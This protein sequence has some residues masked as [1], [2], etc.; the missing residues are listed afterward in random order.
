MGGFFRSF[1]RWYFKFLRLLF[2]SSDS[3]HKLALGGAIGCFWGLTP[4]V[5]L[6]ITILTVTY[7]LLYF[8]NKISANRLKVLE[9]NL[10]IAIAL[11]WVSNPLNAPVLYF[12][13]YAIGVFLLGSESALSFNDFITMLQPLLEIRN[14]L[15]SLDHLGAYF[16]NFKTVL[17]LLGT[18]ILYPLL[19]GCFITAIPSS[20]GFY[21]FLRWFLEHS[22]FAKSRNTK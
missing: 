12:S 2:Y 7:A 5:G 11:T 17:I 15:G 10:P 13:W 6:Q 4:T 9:F 3:K 14:M 21:M 1:K 8:I 20:V 22:K 18:N 16:G 19:L